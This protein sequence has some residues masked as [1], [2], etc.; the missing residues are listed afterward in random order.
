MSTPNTGI[1]YVMNDSEKIRRVE[2]LLKYWDGMRG[3][4]NSVDG[5]ADELRNALY[6]A[7]NVN[8]E[9]EPSE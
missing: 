1:P 6:G 5:C 8:E 3:T 2:A 9:M 4:D 7:G